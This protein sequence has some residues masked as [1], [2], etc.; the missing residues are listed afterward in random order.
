MCVSI[1]FV[2]VILTPP[3]KLSF[4]ICLLPIAY[5][6]RVKLNTSSKLNT[7]KKKNLE[8]ACAPL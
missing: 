7:F 4:I 1:A 2:S 5:L 3:L 6:L 8:A